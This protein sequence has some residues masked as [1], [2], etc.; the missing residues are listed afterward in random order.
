METALWQPS[1]LLHSALSRLCSGRE[2]V[3]L[4][5]RGARTAEA[6]CRLTLDT[7]QPAHH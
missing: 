5:I 3:L 7:Q 4:N 6:A 2:T 1:Q